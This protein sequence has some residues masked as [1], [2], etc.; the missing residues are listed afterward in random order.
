MAYRHSWTLLST[1]L[2]SLIFAG[3]V[4]STP[5]YGGQDKKPQYES[6]VGIYEIT[7]T[8]TLSIT[9][10]GESLY[11]QATGQRTF[12]LIWV[13]EHSFLDRAGNQTVTFVVD[14]AGK[15]SSVTY[16]DPSMLADA[17][18]AGD[19]D[20]VRALIEDGADIHG[21]DTRPRIAGGN[22]RRPLNFASLLGDVQMINT[23][24]ELGADINRQNLSGFTPL[25]H[26][27]EAQALEA[28]ALLVSKGA[29][30]TI[31][32]NRN[33]TPEEFAVASGRSQA[34]AALVT[35]IESK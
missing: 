10:E 21:L 9:L 20:R 17:V 3:L 5:I 16:V 19:V 33:L 22:G 12:E 11:A 7:P 13:F 31:E 25:H 14:D 28:I 29:D 6:Y 34:A 30:T 26:A 15:V 4:Q 32:N 27:V 23:L 24:L 1:T 35:A 2:A 8:V 18:L